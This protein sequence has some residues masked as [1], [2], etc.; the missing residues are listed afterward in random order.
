MLPRADAYPETARTSASVAPVADRVPAPTE[1]PFPGFDGVRLI[2]ATSVVFSH[3]F[4]ISTGTEREEPFIRL[5]GSI[6]GLYGVYTF[7][8][9]SGFLLAR[10]L[11]QDASVIRFAINRALRIYPGVVCCILIT[12]FVIG[13]IGS[14]L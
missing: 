4:L 11:A 10:S 3:A 2:A 1:I 6:L 13:P 12:A 14:S 9:I 5:L 8:I 7:F